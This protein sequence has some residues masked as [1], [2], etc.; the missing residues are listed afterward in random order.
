MTADLP[1]GRLADWAVPSLIL[2][3]LLI[4]FA[5]YQRYPLLT[6]EVFLCAGALLVAGT[7]L[8]L[9]SWLRRE[10]LY[11]LVLGLLILL[12]LDVK[13][14]V[15]VLVMGGAAWVSPLL[16]PF[17][18]L[19]AFFG[20]MFLVFALRREIGRI[21]ASAWGVILLAT[22]LLPGDRIPDGEVFV[23]EARPI[24]DLPLL[25]H[26]I[27]DEHVGVA[28]IPADLPDGRE[29]Q[30]HL[31]AGLSE[32]GFE[33]Y[34][35]AF[36]Q[37]SESHLAL[38]SL[39]NGEAFSTIPEYVAASGSG[40]SITR[41][42]WLGSLS[43]AGYSVRVYQSGWIDFC[44]AQGFS[45]DYCFVYPANG[46][47]VLRDFDL[48]AWSKA[49]LI[50]P[51]IFEGTFDFFP[52]KPQLSSLSSPGVMERLAQD[53]ASHPRGT[54]FFVHLLWPH[55]A[56]AFDAQCALRPDVG[57]WANV[58]NIGAGKE[59]EFN[60]EEARELKYS[61][62]FQQVRCVAKRL[63]DLIEQMGRAG[64][65]SDSVIIVHG[66]HGSRLASKAFRYVDPADFGAADMSDHYSALMAVRMPQSS[67]EK[68]AGRYAD[69]QESIQA[70]FARRFLMRPLSG[71][72]LEVFVRPSRNSATGAPLLSRP[73]IELP[74][75]DLPQSPG[76]TR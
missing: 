60:S 33:V 12:F 49:R 23:R 69:L 13:L 31:V 61:L 59:E 15:L 28:G 58:G 4:S 38:A 20:F 62:Y 5:K 64:S 14:H 44:R 37:Y 47:G 75:A 11:P 7:G 24:Q 32:S 35:R 9:L 40:Y 63:G 56:Y 74:R 41:N 51:R 19:A 48:S 30:E 72:G 1:L 45:A 66:D 3:S 67:D 22:L 50:L 17:L 43:R 8:C 42:D 21:A 16:A 71:S 53:I 73:M 6:P 26:L 2:L 57:T 27:L 55:Y 39:V 25:L 29:L 18:L 10:S 70:I 46:I 65:L 68:A 34:G 76:R 36:S 54:A 52:G